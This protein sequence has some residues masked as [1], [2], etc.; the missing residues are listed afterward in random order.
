MIT[1]SEFYHRLNLAQ[2]MKIGARHI[3]ISTVGVPNAMDKLAQYSTQCTLAISLHAPTQ[4]VR[5]TIVP[6]CAE[7]PPS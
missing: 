2:T 6:R 4:E 1:L 5:E 7:P 3:T